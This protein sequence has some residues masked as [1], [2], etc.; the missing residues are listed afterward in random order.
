M[1]GK[2]LG[3][4]HLTQLA[5]ERE[6]TPRIVAISGYR[7]LYAYLQNDGHRLQNQLERESKVSTREKFDAA[8][9]LLDVRKCFGGSQI[10]TN[11][12]CNR[13]RTNINKTRGYEENIL[14]IS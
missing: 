8:V 1:R 6:H 14:Q 7:N 4:C 5:C 10:L 13:F 9:E 3:E 2:D 11:A 12:I